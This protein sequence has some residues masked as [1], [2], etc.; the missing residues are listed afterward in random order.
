MAEIVAAFGV[1]HTPAFPARVVQ[2]GPG[3]TIARLYAEITRHL[4]AV[5]PEAIVIFDCDHFNS[6]FL[7]NWPTFSVG[8]TTTTSGPN[9]ETPLMQQSIVP[10][11]EPLARAVYRHGIASSFDLAFSQEFEVD[12]SIM[13]P[14]HFLTPKM[15][16]PIVPV[17]INGLVPPLPAAKR[18]FAL[19]Q[20]VRAAV[21]SWPTK[22]RVAVLASGSWTLEVGG[23]RMHAGSTFGVPDWPWAERVLDL[24]RRTK[25]D[26]LLEET[27]GARLAKAGNIAGELLNWIAILGVLGKRQPSFLETQ[28]ELGNAFGA[29]RWD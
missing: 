25:I 19:G 1:P 8:M 3:S 2:E 23:P 4:E 28:P 26:E 14:L 12:H 10:I 21:E 11:D 15:N 5:Q 6:F 16:V 17:F 24:M 9:D 22:M 29:W 20:M 18:C 13:V 7:D 27:T